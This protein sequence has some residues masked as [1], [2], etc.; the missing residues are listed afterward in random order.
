MRRKRRLWQLFPTYFLISLATVTVA[1]VLAESFRSGPG[2]DISLDL[3]LVLLLIALAGASVTFMI[4]YR[5]GRSLDEAHQ[6]A[7]RFAQGDLGFRLRVPASQELGGLAETLNRMAAQLDERIQT[8]IRQRNEQD[9][10]FSSMGEGVIAV[11]PEE[12]ILQTNSAAA[13][14]L[15]INPVLL[16]GRGLSE[17][18]RNTDLHRLLTQTLHNHQAAEGEIIFHGSIERY[19]QVRCTPLRGANHREIG[20][21]IVL[22]DITRIRRLEQ[23]RRDFV[24]NVSHELK[25]PLTSIK[26]FVETL[27]EGD[28]N[29]PAEARRFLIILNNQVER[30]QAIIEDLL[31]LSRLEQQIDQNAIPMKPHRLQDILESVMQLCRHQADAR[32]ITLDLSCHEHCTI[33]C[34][35][36][37]MEQ[38]VMNLVD[39]AVK[40]GNPNTTVRIQV[41]CDPTCC[42]IIV[43]DEGPGIERKH[44]NRIFERF[45]RVDKARS[46]KAGGTGLGLSIVKHIVTAHRGTIAVES[47][48]GR[49]SVFTI[50]LPPADETTAIEQ[51]KALAV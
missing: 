40:Y 25:T 7:I 35:A 11:D 43:A 20:A 48:V 29:D 1:L 4:I 13:G 3:A 33:H 8:I 37:L 27:L 14:L 36:P 22:N 2:F 28:V 42:R 5:L 26:G 31:S 16:H 9:A 30:L 6:G 18:I 15:G 44:L 39:N 17:V 23:M 34:H 45:Y 32:Q 21:L 10:V 49:G 24:A 41:P 12:R 38:A 51:Q 50:T 47:Q 19:L 46:R